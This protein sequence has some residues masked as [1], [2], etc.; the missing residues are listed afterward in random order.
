MGRAPGS[1]KGALW[2]PGAGAGLHQGG[3]VRQAFA[4]IC[5]H[6]KEPITAR[7]LRIA[8]PEAHHAT[9]APQLALGPRDRWRRWLAGRVARRLGGRT[10]AARFASEEPPLV[11]A[12]ASLWARARSAERLPRVGLSPGWWAVL[13]RTAAPSCGRRLAAR[14]YATACPQ[15][16]IPCARRRA[17]GGGVEHP[18]SRRSAGSRRGSRG[19]PRPRSA[20][21]AEQEPHRLRRPHA[22]RRERGR[23]LGALALSRVRRVRQVRRVRRVRESMGRRTRRGAGA[24][25]NGGVAGSARGPTASHGGSRPRQVQGRTGA[26]A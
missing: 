13:R 12:R 15:T 23:R 7:G 6:S 2:I 20:I 3:P 5:R 9:E 10:A 1:T 21:P 26:G 4:D 22:C 24:G 16:A 14:E 25:G 18:D 11:R 19:G 8:F 17:P